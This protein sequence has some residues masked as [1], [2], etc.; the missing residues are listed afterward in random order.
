MFLVEISIIGRLYKESALVKVSE[1]HPVHPGPKESKEEREE[2]RIH[3][4]CLTERIGTSVFL[5]PWTGT[6]ILST[7][8]SWAF[9]LRLDLHF[10]SSGAQVF[11]FKRKIYL[12]LS[13]VS[14]SQTR[15]CQISQQP[16]SHEP[17]PCSKSLCVCVCVCVCMCVCTIMFIIFLFLW[18][19]W[20]IHHLII[21]YGTYRK[22]FFLSH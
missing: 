20:L 18:K 13:W 17:I 2:E 21:I 5:C 19:S 11:C 10:G 1:H 8:C 12:Q 4:L 6:Y 3:S 14:N 7:S 16:Y 15:N 9:R 22:F